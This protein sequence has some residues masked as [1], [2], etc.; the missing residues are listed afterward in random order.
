VDD[1]ACP[2]N[3]I[4]SVLML[5]E[6]WDVQNVTVVVGLR[7]YTAKANIL[8][9]QTIGRGLRL[10]FRGQGVGYLERVD[11]I[12][13]KAFLDFVEDLERLEE[14]ELG[15][16]QVGKDKLTILT[17]QPVLP[18]K[19]AFDIAI[20]QLSPILQRKKS[21][22]AE[23]ESIDVRTFLCPPPPKRPGDEAERK[24]RYNGYDFIT[25]EREFEREYTIPTPQTSGEVVGYYSRMI[26]K[27]LKLPAQFAALAPKV[28]EFFAVKAF[29]GPV[30][31]EDP[32]IIQAMA[33]PPVA[34][35]V[36]KLFTNALGN[37]I[38]EELEPLLRSPP[39]PV[40]QSQ[41]RRRA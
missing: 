31:L 16:F 10:M 18:E 11:I 25:L 26:A 13:N 15:R 23:I 19:S 41:C 40:L 7:P 32:T 5:R 3:A 17:I 21:L 27:D 30:D 39:F 22:A 28:R 8:P 2:V 12:G 36:K 34:Y 6:G 35:V 38:V 20:P 9:E 29:G 4:V 33:R 1:P 14:L 24:F 37:G